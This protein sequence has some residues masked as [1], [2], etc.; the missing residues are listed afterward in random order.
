M[1]PAAAGVK[2]RHIDTT[3]VD[4]IRACP[5]GKWIRGVPVWVD[6]DDASRIRAEALVTHGE[7]VCGGQYRA[8]KGNFKY[9]PEGGV[10]SFSWVVLDT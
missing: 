10:A 4:V 2:R 9:H 5:D 8:H 6:S 3:D 7:N 1:I